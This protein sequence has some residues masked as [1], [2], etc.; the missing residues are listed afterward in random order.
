VKLALYMDVHVPAAITRGLRRRRIDVLTAQEDGAAT[1]DDP[2]LLDRASELGRVVFTRDRDFLAEAVRRQR[3]DLPFATV[4][5][6]H[7]Q[8][9][10]IGRCIEDLVLV[11][12]ASDSE[13]AVRQI[14]FLPL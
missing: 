1:L 11:A 6:A 12:T 2:G 4:V 5:Y 13:D 14:V 3:N 10:S 8:Q 9:V 7:Q